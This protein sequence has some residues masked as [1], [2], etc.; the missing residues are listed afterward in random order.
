MRILAATTAVGIAVAWPIAARQRGPV[1]SEFIFETAPYPSVP[2]VDD[3]RTPRRRPG[4]GVVRRHAERNPDVGIWVSRH[5]AG[6]GRRPSKSPTA[7]S[8]PTLRHPTWNPVLFQP[9]QGPLLL[10]YKVGPSPS[11]WWGMLTTSA[12]GGRTWATPQRLP[13]GI[14]G[15]IKNKPVQL[16]NGDMLSGSST[17]ARRLARSLRTVDRRRPHVDRNAAASTTASRVGAIQPS[18]LFH[19]RTVASRRSAA[20]ETAV[21]EIW[22][23]TAARRGARLVWSRC[24]TRAPAPTPSP[25]ATA[26]SCSSTTTPTK[27]RSPLNVAMST[28]RQRLDAGARARDEPGAEFSYPAVIQTTDGLVHITYTWKRQRIKHVVLEIKR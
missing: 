12:D 20:R 4:R 13:D 19:G 24:R 15:P 16:A 27:G 10:F 14:L 26:G 28:R 22:S 11:T 18:I 1:S 2:R 21:F 5:E 25:C 7:C 23:A 17:E 3:R 9:K 8:R 6:S